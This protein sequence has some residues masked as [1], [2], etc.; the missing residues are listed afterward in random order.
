MFFSKIPNIEYDQKPLSFPVSEKTYVLAKNLFRKVNIIDAI[1][2]NSV[3]YNKYTITDDDR[4]DLISQKFYGSTDYD[5]VI[6]LTNNL[7][8][9]NFDLPI[10]ESR[11]YDFVDRSYQSDPYEPAQANLL[12]AD[13]THHYATTELKN[14]LGEVLLKEGLVVDKKYYDTTHKFY[15]R[16]TNQYLTK[17]GNEL[18]EQVSNYQYEKNL[19]DSRRE[20]YILRSDLLQKF[21]VQF[22]NLLEY[23]DSSSYIDTKTKRAGI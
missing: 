1:Y 4:L 8:N 14:S 23:T 18:C 22:E 10:K 21:V 15:D 9:T 13:R 6:L 20:I 7:I 12:P 11:L 5:W 3:Y 17:A 16:G 2:N 19:N